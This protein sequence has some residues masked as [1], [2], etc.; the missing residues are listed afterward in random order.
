MIQPATHTPPSRRNLKSKWLKR[1]NVAVSSSERRRNHLDPSRW[2]KKEE[3]K[4]IPLSVLNT[5]SP[6]PPTAAAATTT[7]ATFVCPSW[8][9]TRFLSHLSL[10]VLL[11]INKERDKKKMTRRRDSRHVSTSSELSAVHKAT[12]SKCLFTQM[13]RRTSSDL[14]HCGPCCV[15]HS[16]CVL[17]LAST[18]TSIEMQMFQKSFVVA[19][20]TVTEMVSACNQFGPPSSWKKTTTT[21]IAMK[22]SWLLFQV[23]LFFF[24]CS[25]FARLLSIFFFFN[26]GPNSGGPCRFASTLDHPFTTA[27]PPYPNRKSE[28]ENIQ[29]I[30]V[31]VF[32]VLDVQI[33]SPQKVFLLS[34]SPCTSSICYG[35]LLLLLHGALRVIKRLG[36]I[37]QKKNEKKKKKKGKCVQSSP[38]FT[39]CCC[40]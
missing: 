1:P 30:R 28:R 6:P 35:R 40:S 7:T 23:F 27:A 31:R 5:P 29:R 14:P 18:T 9:A 36:T 16:L 39:C 22:E 3:T 34:R 19:F 26:L 4:S 20:A 37:R 25:H 32:C 2:E 12:I 33:L 13:K 38:L 15:H 8:N 10:D 17:F 24:K 21:T 11:S